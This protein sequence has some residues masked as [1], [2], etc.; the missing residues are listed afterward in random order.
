LAYNY[1]SISSKHAGSMAMLRVV[2][3]M[4]CLLLA[5][6]PG[7]AQ[8]WPNRPVRLIA[9]FPAGA[10]TDITARV[11]AQ[12]LSVRLG[13]PFVVEN[14]PGASG[15]IGAQIVAKAEPDGYTLLVGSAAEIA[16]DQLL[17]REMSYDPAKD[18]A[19][20]SLL[21]WTPLVLAAHPSFEASTVGQL[22]DMAAARQVDFSTPGIGSAM[23][24]T[25]EYIKK[26]ANLKLVHVPYKGAAPAVADAVAGHVKLTIAGIPPTAPFLKSG[27]LKGLAVTSKQRSTLFPDIPAMAETATF[28]DFDFT[29]WI[30][31][32]ARANTPDEILRRLHEASAEALQAPA[33]RQRLTAVAA[34]PVGSTP[35][36]FRTFIS[37]EVAKY[38]RIVKL[39]GIE[40]H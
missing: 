29:N 13:Q 7:H 21:V 24:L 32:L 25:G 17:N 12:E 37:S 20:V 39:A 22:I 23:H 16:L 38:A 1:F 3:L 4:L 31:L 19:A 33:V 40:A 11:L 18:F 27:A 2:I 14:R 8:D 36:E 28:S 30:G 9:P 34:E 5:G 6:S 35:E 26:I 10:L 15:M